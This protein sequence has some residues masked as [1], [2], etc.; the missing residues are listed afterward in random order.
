MERSN[1][2]TIIELL[3]VISIMAILATLAIP[4]Y[5]DFFEKGRLR[6]AT[7]AVYEQLQYARA[8]ALKRS[9]PIIVD[10]SDEV[11]LDDGSTTW[12]LG[13]T[14]K[15]GGCDAKDTIT[16]PCTIEY[17][18]DPNKD[19]D[20]ADVDNDEDTGVLDPVFM[21]IE[22]V[23]FSNITMSVPS[24][25]TS[26]GPGSCATKVPK[27]A[28]FEPIR[29]LSRKTATHIELTNGDYKL[30]VRVDEVGG[31]TICRPAGSNYF[32]GYNDCPK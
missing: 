2:F 21:R 29:G 8:Q 14:D 26:D 23:D 16:D 20:N 19:S 5:L 3:V 22:G 24:F 15:F 7:E 12:A 18:N 9:T 13:I 11:L 32:V 6:G 27:Q 25:G 10:F 4:S 28:C 30:Q 1:G 17:D 31:V